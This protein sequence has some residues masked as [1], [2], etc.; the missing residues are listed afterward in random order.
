MEGSLNASV[1]E[2]EAIGNDFLEASPN[3]WLLSCLE[4][5]TSDLGCS[6]E[7][8]NATGLDCL[9]LDIVILSVSFLAFNPKVLVALNFGLSDFRPRNRLC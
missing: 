9:G 8:F 7:G 4:I 2:V 1:L 5:L 3:L 6:F